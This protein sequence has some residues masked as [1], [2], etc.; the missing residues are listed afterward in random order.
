MGFPGGASG[1][2]PICQ[3][4]T[5]KRHGFDPWVGKN[6]RRKW[7]PTPVFL[8]EEIHGPRSLAG[9][10]PW[11]HKASHRTERPALSLPIRT[12]Q[13]VSPGVFFRGCSATVPI[14]PTGPLWVS[15]S[16]S[17]RSLSSPCFP[18]HKVQEERTR[19]QALYGR[20][21]ASPPPIWIGK[22]VACPLS[23]AT[24]GPQSVG[25]PSPTSQRR[26]RHGLQSPGLLRG[27]TALTS[28][29]NRCGWGASRGTQGA[30][31]HQQREEESEEPPRSCLPALVAQGLTPKVFPGA[32][33]SRARVWPLCHGQG[34]LLP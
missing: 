27:A 16:A 11:G 34:P 6:W 23:P 21:A 26:T 25:P 17:G 18:R 4:R 13:R 19:V 3:C 22:P 14:P 33:C 31:A 20:N 24:C 32:Q 28:K 7:Q 5:H 10:S 9:Y 12:R 1:K 15:S 8:P 29:E 2:E 30:Q